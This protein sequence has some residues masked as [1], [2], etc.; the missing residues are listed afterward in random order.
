MIEAFADDF[1]DGGAPP[2]SREDA[3]PLSPVRH[4]SRF[5]AIARTAPVTLSRIAREGT[6]QGCGGS[7]DSQKQTHF[8]RNFAEFSFPTRAQARV[9]R[10]LLW[11]VRERSAAMLQSRSSS[12]S[13]ISLRAVH[14]LPLR[15]NT[16]YHLWNAFWFPFLQGKG[17]GVRSAISTKRSQITHNSEAFSFLIPLPLQGKGLGV[18]SA[19]ASPINPRIL[20]ERMI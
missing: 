3:L 8:I 17:L 16:S 10:I 19:D 12:A 2:P 20:L 14:E 1:R 13:A 6:F 18:R 15:R 9:R 7:V 11:V 5:A 4:G